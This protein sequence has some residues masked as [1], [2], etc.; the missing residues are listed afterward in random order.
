M[1]LTG[2]KTNAYFVDVR[3]DLDYFGPKISDAE[4]ALKHL[5][6]AFAGRSRTTS[7]TKDEHGNRLSYHCVWDHWI[8]SKSDSPDVDEGDMLPQNDGTVLE[9]GSMRDPATGQLVQYEEL[10][11]DLDVDP[12][13]S[14][15]KRSS[16]VVK[17]EDSGA[18]TRGLVIKVGGFCQ[19]ILKHDGAFTVERWKKESP[20]ASPEHA[21]SVEATRTRNDWIRIFRTGQGVLPCE[22]ICS[23]TDGKF[24]SNIILKDEQEISWRVVEEYYY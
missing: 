16:I 8:D 9:Q 4:D 18:G 12:I 15:G 14:K 7:E 23:R 10:W 3:L 20:S 2:S 19:G 24:G 11:E 22:A 13:G 5:Q 21:A 6:W 1:V 17:T